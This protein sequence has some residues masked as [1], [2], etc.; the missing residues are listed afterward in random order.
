[1][2]AAALVSL[3]ALVVLVLDGLALS[4]PYPHIPHQMEILEEMVLLGNPS[5]LVG[6]LVLVEQVETL[7]VLLPQM[8]LVETVEMEL[9]HQ[10]LVLP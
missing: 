4:I 6:A 3:M 7:A 10:L 2:V 5:V 9:H 1:M 8:V